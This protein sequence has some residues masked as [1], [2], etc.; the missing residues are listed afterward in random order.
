M[1]TRQHYARLFLRLLITL[2]SVFIVG[3][4]VSTKL[5]DKS[6]I[7]K[8]NDVRESNTSANDKTETLSSQFRS[9]WINTKD[10]TRVHIVFVNNGGSYNAHTGEAQGVAGVEVVGGSQKATN[11]IEQVVS[12]STSESEQM[13]TQRD[14]VEVLIQH[15][16][17]ESEKTIGSNWWVWL[18][19][20]MG[21]M[22]VAIV[23]LRRL[24]QTM[25]LF[26]W[27]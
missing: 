9:L 2:F 15:N 20:G 23:V 11:E 25:W 17:I 21:A 6:E 19:I 13:V 1:K 5:T 7:N 16:D 14:S 12:D 8:I 24:P 4:N 3:C 10:S 18:L 22:L 26:S 27:I